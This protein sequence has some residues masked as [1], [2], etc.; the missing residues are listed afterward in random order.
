MAI[1]HLRTD[2]TIG[3]RRSFQIRFICAIVAIEHLRTDAKIVTHLFVQ[4][5]P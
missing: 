4:L 3:D 5:W 2:A 1:E